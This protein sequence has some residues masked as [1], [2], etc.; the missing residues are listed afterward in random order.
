MSKE[1]NKTSFHIIGGHATLNAIMKS[2]GSVSTGLNNADFIIFMGGTDINSEIYGEM[3]H[4]KAQLPNLARDAYETAIYRSTPQQ[5]RVGICRGAQLL[6]ALNGGK[7][8][9]HVEHHV[10]THDLKYMTENGL[11]RGY[12][13]SSTHHQMM[14]GPFTDGIV[15]GFANKTRK[16]ELVTGHAFLVGDDHW[17]D[18]EIVHYR[19]SQTLCFQ[20]HPEMLA[21]KQTREL[22]LRCLVRMVET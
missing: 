8:W 20:P 12:Q 16:R 10:G 9:Q 6:H 21:P 15:W 19:K 2:F 7:L 11:F 17:S 14:R 13:V 4:Q 3:P 22:F 5:Y 18:P 1:L